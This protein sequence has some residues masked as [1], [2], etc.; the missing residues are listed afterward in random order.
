MLTSREYLNLI[1]G[2]TFFHQGCVAAT[3]PGGVRVEKPWMWS[4]EAWG[5]YILGV[6][7]TKR[8]FGEPTFES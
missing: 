8:I 6:R 2:S 3:D 1:A 4:E 7:E 5:M